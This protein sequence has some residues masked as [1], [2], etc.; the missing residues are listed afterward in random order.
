M[1]YSVFSGTL[2]SALTIV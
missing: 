1:I 2:N